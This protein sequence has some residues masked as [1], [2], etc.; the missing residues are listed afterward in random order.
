M[1][2]SRRP[3]RRKLVKADAK[4]A[5]FRE[6]TDTGRLVSR[7]DFC[8]RPFRLANVNT[9]YL[10]RRFRCAPSARQTNISFRC[11]WTLVQALGGTDF[12]LLCVRA[13]GGG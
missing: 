13:R 9:F 8:A 3:S 5:A 11:P 1:H 2:D 6:R 4:E 12:N 7:P 10:F